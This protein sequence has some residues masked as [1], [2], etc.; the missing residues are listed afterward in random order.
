MI[1]L[2]PDD[3]NERTR[4]KINSNFNSIPSDASHLPFTPTGNITATNVQSAITQVAVDKYITAVAGSNG[5]F[6]VTT[7]IALAT[8]QIVYIAFPSAT[9]GASNA[10]LSVDG[11]TTYKNIK[12]STIR[13]ASEVA[14]RKLSLTYDGTDFVPLDTTHYE[15]WGNILLNFA[16]PIGSIYETTSSALDTIAKMATQF[17]GT[18]EVFGAGKV[19]VAINSADTE[20]DVLLET[21]GAKTHTLDTTQ[22]PSHA[23]GIIFRQVGVNANYQP[24]PPMTSAGTTTASNTD[25]TGGGLAHNNLQPYIVVYR[26]RRLT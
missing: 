19:L 25:A 12:L 8:N 23:H 14:S 10:R 24:Y 26:Y 4:Q 21:G 9:N 16:Y 22:I 3:N 6:Y 11:G 18:W 13:I 7:P 5:D 1:R 2:N 17:G 15:L 20:F